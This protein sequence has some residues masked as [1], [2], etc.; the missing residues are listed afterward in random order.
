MHSGLIIEAI[1]GD[2]LWTSD[3]GQLEE[4]HCVLLIEGNERRCT[5]D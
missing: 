2:V 5:V 4:M 3:R 1:R